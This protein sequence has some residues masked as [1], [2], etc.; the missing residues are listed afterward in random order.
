VVQLTREMLVRLGGLLAIQSSDAREY[1]ADY[2]GA[3]RLCAAVTS[4]RH[5]DQ[6]RCAIRLPA[7]GESV[8]LC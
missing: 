4:G 1:R 8:A 5:G 2:S 3:N 7:C 6:A